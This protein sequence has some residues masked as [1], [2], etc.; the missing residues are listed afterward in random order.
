LDDATAV[1]DGERR[2]VEEFEL[3]RQWVPIPSSGAAQDTMRIT[4]EAA[5]TGESGALFEWTFP[6]GGPPRGF[7]LSPVP[8]PLT[9]IGGPSFV[10]GQI[11][12]GRIGV[13]PVTVQIREVV[14]Y[15]PTLDPG[16]GPFLVVNLETINL[17][18]RSLP[19]PRVVVPSAHWIGLEPGVDSGQVQ[20]LLEDILPPGQTTIRNREAAVQRVKSNP[21][22]GG[23]WRGLAFLALGALLG[24]AILGYVLYAALA[25]Q[26]NRLELG[27]LRALGFTRR[28]VALLLGLGGLIVALVGL[29]VGIATGAWMG[30]WILGYLDVT[31]GG[32]TVAPPMLLAQDP[33]LLGLAY[34]GVA[35]AAIL[36]TL[37]ALTLANRLHL[38]EVLRVEE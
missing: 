9:A 21:L 13:Q 14:Q 30:Q 4:N 31:A 11:V 19:Q 34:G 36:A 16:D 7:F 25:F 23:P 29:S 3:I 12:L 15:F 22:A 1:V 10:P 27:L 18:Q 5:R 2:V 26:Y 33:Q 38:P 35:L 28:Q 6:L 37:L 24:V 32:Q 8:L 20:T 17:L